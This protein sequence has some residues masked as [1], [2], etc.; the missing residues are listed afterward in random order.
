MKSPMNSERKAGRLFGCSAWLGRESFK[1]VV[2]AVIT[3]QRIERL[4]SAV[5]S[6]MNA[7]QKVMKELSQWFTIKL[8]ATNGTLRVTFEPTHR[9]RVF[10]K[11]GKAPGADGNRRSR[12]GHKVRKRPNVEVS[13]V[14]PPLASETEKPRTGTRSLH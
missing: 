1:T 12:L 11:T 5:E 4:R 7:S 3:M 2:D 10:L 14:C 9:M 6:R 13:D 8:S